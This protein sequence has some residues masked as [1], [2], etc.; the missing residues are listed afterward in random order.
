[1][2]YFLLEALCL[3]IFKLTQGLELI[4]DRY[5]KK[6]DMLPLFWT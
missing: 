2:Q 6:G 4:V 1:M 5:R 3:Y